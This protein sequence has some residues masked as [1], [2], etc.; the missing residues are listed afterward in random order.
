MYKPHS[1]HWSM[2]PKQVGLDLCFLVRSMESKQY[3]KPSILGYITFTNWLENRDAERQ[4]GMVR[5]GTY[6]MSMFY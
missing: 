4:K 1:V 3:S 6:M 5:M 2:Q